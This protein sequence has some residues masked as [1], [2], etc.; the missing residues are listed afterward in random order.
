MHDSKPADGLAE[1]Y[2]KISHGGWPADAMRA[3]TGSAG[4]EL[5][6]SQGT[7]QTHG[8]ALDQYGKG[9][10]LALKAGKPVTAWSVP[11]GDSRGWWGRLTG[12]PIPQDGLV[13]NH[14]YTV[15]SVAKD[16]SGE[17]Q[18]T[19]RNPW[20]TNMGVGEGK[21]TASASITV[22]LRELVDTGGLNSFRVG[23]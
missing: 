11:E 22:P 14:V 2:N 13:D 12:A 19:L 21:D 8:S 20:A 6:F 17:W 4:S 23:N 5:K 18:V 7:F 15:Q 10:E 3:V 1:G 16:G 9:V